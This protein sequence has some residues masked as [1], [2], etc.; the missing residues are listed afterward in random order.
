M[1]VDCD[2]QELI[3]YGEN[4]DSGNWQTYIYY[5]SDPLPNTKTEWA[6]FK[7]NSDKNYCKVRS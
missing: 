5:A 2:P 1:D 4:Y 3:L 6:R 7:I